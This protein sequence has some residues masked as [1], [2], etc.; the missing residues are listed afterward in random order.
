[1]GL[2]TDGQRRWFFAHLDDEASQGAAKTVAHGDHS[3]AAVNAL[4]KSTRD[5]VL[6]MEWTPSF[7]RKPWKV[8]L[9]N[10]K[11]VRTFATGEEAHAFLNDEV[12]V[13]RALKELAF[14]GGLTPSGNPPSIK[15]LID[16][17]EAEVRASRSG[18]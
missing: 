17:K 10:G 14:P 3:P 6:T 18:R 13:R 11:T 9:Q 16:R 1:M 4:F 5:H 8:T 15:G 12:R 2:E 7:S